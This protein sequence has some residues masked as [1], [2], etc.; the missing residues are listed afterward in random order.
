[1]ITFDSE[2]AVAEVNTLRANPHATREQ[3][4]ELSYRIAQLD[5]MS[6][7]WLACACQMRADEIRNRKI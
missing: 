7:H 4:L 1:M 2:T 5:G 3:W 6:N